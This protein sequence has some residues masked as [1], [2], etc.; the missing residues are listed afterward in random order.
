M[1]SSSTE[2]VTRSIGKFGRF[3]LFGIVALCVA[4]VTGWNIGAGPNADPP[5]E[6]NQMVDVAK[7]DASDARIREA[8]SIVD[9]EYVWRLRLRPEQLDAV[10]A[11]QELPQ[12]D[13]L[14]DTF[15]AA[16]PLLWRPVTTKASQFFATEQFPFTSR[17]PDGDHWAAMYDPEQQFLYVW[18]K[19]NF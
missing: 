12:S 15:N 19:G 11:D 8:F 9:C 13:G 6:F 16:F 10:V 7:V 3:A 14:P 1:T 4:G 18:F 5:Y 2:E 17:G